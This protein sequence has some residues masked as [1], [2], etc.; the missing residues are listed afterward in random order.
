MRIPGEKRRNMVYPLCPQATKILMWKMTLKQR[1]RH[2]ELM[3]QVE[4]MRNDP[5]LWPPEDYVP[6]ES[7]EEDEKYQK[8]KTTFQDLVEELYQLEQDVR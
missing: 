1:R 8:A 2:G 6:G 4:G 3:A 5:Y 7:E